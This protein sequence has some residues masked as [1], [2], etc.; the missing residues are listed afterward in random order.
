MSHHKTAKKVQVARGKLVEKRQVQSAGSA[1][2]TRATD[3]T[4]VVLAA[5]APLSSTD[6]RRLTSR[7]VRF[8]DL[9]TLLGG[10]A[11]SGLAAATLAPALPIAV[12]AATAAGSIAAFVIGRRLEV[13]EAKSTGT[14]GVTAEDHSVSHAFTAR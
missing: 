7:S 10:A 4:L 13:K 14:A 6:A 9:A 2:V 8:I 11:S 5:G 1:G 3:P 12:V